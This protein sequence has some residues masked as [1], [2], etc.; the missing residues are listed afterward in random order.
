MRGLLYIALGLITY[1][2]QAQLLPALF[3]WGWLPN[4]ILVWIVIITLVK[5]RKA[6]IIAAIV[7]GLL[8]DIVITNF[9]GLHLFPYLLVALLFSIKRVTVYEEQWYTSILLVMIGTV[10]E[11]FLQYSLLFL[12][13]ENISWLSWFWQYIWP[14]I[15]VN[16][17]LGIAI[18]EVIW[19]LEEQDEYIW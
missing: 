10:L 12:A 9:F 15:W 4:L 2:L 14:T 19:N 16:G 5:G 17:I 6:G 3:H 8:Q 11:A 7:G 1:F 13:K 18:H